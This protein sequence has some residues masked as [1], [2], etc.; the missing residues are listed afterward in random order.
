MKQQR[1][2]NQEDKLEPT[3]AL[4]QLQCELFEEPSVLCYGNERSLRLG[5]SED[6]DLGAALEAAITA[7]DLK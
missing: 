7:S 1:I 6:G 4:N 2:R 3:T 5:K